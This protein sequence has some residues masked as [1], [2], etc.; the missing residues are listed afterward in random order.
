MINFDTSTLFKDVQIQSSKF[1]IYSVSD[2]VFNNANISATASD[3]T[4]E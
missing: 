1:I 3:C 4:V 2:L